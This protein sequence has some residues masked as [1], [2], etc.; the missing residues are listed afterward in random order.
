MEYFRHERRIVAG[1]IF[2]NFVRRVYD[3]LCAA[4]LYVRLRGDYNHLNTPIFRRRHAGRG[5]VAFLHVFRPQQSFNIKILDDLRSA[6]GVIPI[7]MGY[8]E[9]IYAFYAHFFQ[10]LCHLFTVFGSSRVHEQIFAAAGH[11]E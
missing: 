9:I 8:H 4:Q 1:I 2:I 3:E 6:A 7:K 5:F 10:A 11:K